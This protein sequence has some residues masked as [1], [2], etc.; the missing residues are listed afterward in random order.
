MRLFGY[1]LPVWRQDD[2]VYQVVERVTNPL[3]L[4]RALEATHRSLVTWRDA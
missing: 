3:T 4:T 2:A 1:V